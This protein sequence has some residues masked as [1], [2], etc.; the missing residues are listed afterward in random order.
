MAARENIVLA[1]GVTGTALAMPLTQSHYGQIVAFGEFAEAAARRGAVCQPYTYIHTDIYS[2]LHIFASRQ[3][4]P[5]V[6]SDAG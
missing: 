2:N 4:F 5:L 3:L 1:A 6:V